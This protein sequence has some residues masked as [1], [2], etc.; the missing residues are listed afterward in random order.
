MTGFATVIKLMLGVSYSRRRAF[1]YAKVLVGLEAVRASSVPAANKA[2][3]CTK[4]ETAATANAKAETATKANDIA[5]LAI[6]AGIKIGK[7]KAAT[8]S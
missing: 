1:I 7:R 5:K 4:A 3:P 2:R 6:A 8:D